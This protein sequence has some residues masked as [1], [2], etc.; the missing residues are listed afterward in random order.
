M[1]I[2]QEL[3]K[4]VSLN[5]K[6]YY[7]V[8]I[9]KLL[10]SVTTVIGEFAD[11]SGIK[12]WIE[13]VGADKAEKITKFSANRGTVMHQMIEYFLTSFER[14]E[15]LRLMEA[16]EKIKGYCES[17]GFTRDER[18]MG[19][20]LFYNFYNTDTFDRIKRV[21]KLEEAVWSTK[22]GGFAGR[23][24]AIYENQNG[25][26]II[27]DFKT[28][29]K[30]KKRKWIDDYFLQASAYYI[31]YWEMTGVKPEGGE[32]WISNEQEGFPQVFEIYEKDMQ[33]YGAKFLTMVKDFHAKYNED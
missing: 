11:K 31:A 17:E 30:A 29:R 15:R 8:G 2:S 19:E 5:G 33:Y 3:K 7:D 10:P 6:R 4:T 21:D 13:R 25:G 28:A 20:R 12:H 22:N 26:I 23:T 14:E 9:D 32:I 16:R 24:D 27:L 1:S 18:R